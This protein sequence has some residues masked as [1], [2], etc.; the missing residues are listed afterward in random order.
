MR[1]QKEFFE[2]IFNE[3]LSGESLEGFPRK[4]SVILVSDN[5]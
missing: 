4:G 5:M 2:Q 1:N 3:K